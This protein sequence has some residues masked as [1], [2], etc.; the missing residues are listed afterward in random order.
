MKQLGLRMGEEATV[1]LEPD[2]STYGA[3][4]PEELTE[5]LRQDEEGHERFHVLSPGK[6]RYII[7]YVGAVKSSQLRID[8]AIRL[9]ENLKRLPRGKE[10]FREI[11][12]LEKQR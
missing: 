7:H 2:H 11:L 3:E 4:V 9:I 6:Q 5:L 1:A 12:G 10:D 8:R